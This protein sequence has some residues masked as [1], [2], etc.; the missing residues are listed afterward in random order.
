[1]GPYSNCMIGLSNNCYNGH[2]P[3]PSAMVS[4]DLW[5]W[6]QQTATI[7]IMVTTKQPQLW[8]W[9]QQTDTM[10]NTPNTPNSLVHCSLFFTIA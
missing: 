4:L 9:L 7:E 1:M 2:C 6:L 8:S 10:K 3:L 5:S